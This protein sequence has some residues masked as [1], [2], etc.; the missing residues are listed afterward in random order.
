MANTNFQRKR[1]EGI[2]SDQE[3]HLQDKIRDTRSIW[4]KASDSFTENPN[5][6][7]WILIG[8]FAAIVVFPFLMDFLMFWI[9]VVG[10]VLL[11]YGRKNTFTI[12]TPQSSGTKVRDKKWFS[13]LL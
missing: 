11:S 10:M 8:M 12:E 2:S 1:F 4:K 13:S 6:L 5:I 9:G 3:L 7:N